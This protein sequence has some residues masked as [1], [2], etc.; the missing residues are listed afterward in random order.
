MFCYA[1]LHKYHKEITRNHKERNHLE[2]LRLH[3]VAHEITAVDVVSTIVAAVYNAVRVLE[4]GA[5]VQQADAVALLDV[6]VEVVNGEESVGADRVRGLVMELGVG[7][8]EDG[9][10]RP[11]FV[12]FFVLVDVHGHRHAQR[13]IDEIVCGERKTH[14]DESL[15]ESDTV[16]LGDDANG[17]D[18]FAVGYAG[19]VERIRIGVA[20][21][22]VVGVA[23]EDTVVDVL[24]VV[25][26]R[27]GV[28]AT[29]AEVAESVGGNVTEAESGGGKHFVLR[30]GRKEERKNVG[31]FGGRLVAIEHTCL[32]LGQ[33]SDHFFRNN[34]YGIPRLSI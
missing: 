9:F 25:V 33:F 15:L 29:T 11:L 19:I 5:V 4:R 7:V 22:H 13:K 2:S 20:F 1:D 10:H 6:R 28:A 16:V 32:H 21:A 27:R 31:T 3:L 26:D 23:A 17:V 24:D 14:V 12:L 30:K 8:L 18:E 34:R